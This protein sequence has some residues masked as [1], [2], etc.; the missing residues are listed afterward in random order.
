M[1]SFSFIF[2]TARFFT[3][4]LLQ[5]IAHDL[6]YANYSIFQWIMTQYFRKFTIQEQNKKKTHCL[7][8]NNQ[9]KLQLLKFL[10]YSFIIYPKGLQ[11]FGWLYHSKKHYVLYCPWYF[12]LF[13]RLLTDNT[14][15]PNLKSRGSLI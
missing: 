1:L 2:S 5:V 6:I 15:H 3:K 7:D 4:N 10:L 12:G 14:K 8:V 9:E 13:D 11:C